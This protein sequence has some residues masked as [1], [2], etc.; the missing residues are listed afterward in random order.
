[1]KLVMRHLVIKALE[2]YRLTAPY[3]QP[4]CRFYPS[5]SGYAIEALRRH[6]LVAGGVLAL[7]R[8]LRCQPFLRGGVDTVPEEM[9]MP[10]GFR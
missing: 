9:V 1:M 10:W 2:F 7:W 4:R 8:L 6:G 3:R 5:C